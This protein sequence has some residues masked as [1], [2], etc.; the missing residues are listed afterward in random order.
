MCMM[1]LCRKRQFY[2]DATGIQTCLVGIEGESSD[3]TI[4]CTLSTYCCF[5]AH[6]YVITVNLKNIFNK[7]WT[8]E[9]Q[10]L[11]VFNYKY[12]WYQ[13]KYKKTLNV[14]SGLEPDAA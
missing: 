13:L 9:S 1:I 7:I 2:F 11:F 4:K 12:L 3:H 5:E 6:A 8:N 14:C 10:F